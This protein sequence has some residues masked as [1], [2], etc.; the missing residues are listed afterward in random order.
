MDAGAGI[1][2]SSKRA[3]FVFTSFLKILAQLI[4]DLRSISY[5]IGPKIYPSYSSVVLSS[6]ATTISHHIHASFKSITSST[7]ATRVILLLLLFLPY[8]S[9]FHPIP[10]A[11]L[12][13]SSS[14]A[15]APLSTPLSTPTYLFEKRINDKRRRE[16]GIADD[17]DEYDLD[18]ALDQNT[19]PFI[20]KVIAGSLILAIGGLLVV[21]VII[22][23]TAPQDGMMCNPI[24]NAGRC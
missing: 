21:G 24:Q 6:L 18:V 17:E 9:A 22:P 19:D 5:A 11:L 15:L 8:L 16:L 12:A 20:T 3:L 14:P 2:R 7:M 13:R 1:V 10:R 23:M 4:I